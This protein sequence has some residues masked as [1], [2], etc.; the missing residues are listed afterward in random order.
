MGF[1][2]GRLQHYIIHGSTLRGVVALDGQALR[3]DFFIKETFKSKNSPDYRLPFQNM[4]NFLTYI[5]CVLEETA[6]GEIKDP[7]W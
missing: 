6:L 2:S 5:A 3:L 1:C 7:T 4:T